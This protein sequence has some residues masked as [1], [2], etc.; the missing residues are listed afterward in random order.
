MNADWLPLDFEVRLFEG[1]LPQVGD[2]GCLDYGHV[3]CAVCPGGFARIGVLGIAAPDRWVVMCTAHGD[4]AAI[5]KP[6]GIVLATEAAGG[7]A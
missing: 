6:L 4:V 2:P 5:R 3:R 1:I 7:A